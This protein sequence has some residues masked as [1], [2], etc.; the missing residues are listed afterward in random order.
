MYDKILIPTDGSPLSLKAARAGAELAKRLGATLTAVYVIPSFQPVYAADGV[1][2]SNT[3]SQ[4]EYIDAM[5]ATA[6]QALDKVAAI[7][8]KLDVACDE[9]SMESPSAWEGIIKAAA[10]FKCDTIVMSSHG[11]SGIA[12]VVLGSQT[13]RVLTHSKIPV[14]VCR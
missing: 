6:Q 11:R 7:A 14:L 12:G 3:F 9:R 2:F 5:K 4:K 1:Y 10:K 13:Q 8:R